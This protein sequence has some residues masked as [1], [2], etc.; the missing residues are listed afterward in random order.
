MRINGSAIRSELAINDIQLVEIGARR[1]RLE[2]QRDEASVIAFP[3]DLTVSAR[4][5]SHVAE[6]LSGQAN[7]FQKQ[8]EA[9][10]QTRRQRLTRIEEIGSQIQGLGAQQEAIET[11]ISI[12]QADLA[13]QT[14]LLSN[15]L[16]QS[17][18]VSALERE[19]AQ[20]KGRLGELISARA[21]AEGQGT[22]IEIE[23][24]TL[25]TQQQE[26]TETELREVVARELELL[27]QK[28]AILDRIA[29]L[30]V[31]APSSGRVLGLQVT[32]PQSVI[33]S[34]DV[35][36]YIVPQDRPLLVS[37]RVPVTHVDEVRPGQTVRL[38][39]ASFPARTTPE[40]FGTVTLVSADVLADE[41]TGMHYYRAE[42]AL[43]D[44]ALWNLGDLHILPG[45]TVDA[46]IL[47]VDRTPLSYLLKPFADYFRSAFRE[48]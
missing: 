32:T 8:A 25:A 13:T 47:T 40:I 45:M 31:R 28:K 41:R 23:I 26:K 48:T 21:E 19:L 15:G 7:L 33:R 44:E 30:D 27:E 6:I 36:M 42:I 5:N 16:T 46:F 17:E 22:E 12:A 34:A 37:A 1:A 3:H 38:V 11:Q 39:F 24:T 18:R 14:A 9:L 20:L 35:L 4:S 10:S 2:A 43:D 29:Q